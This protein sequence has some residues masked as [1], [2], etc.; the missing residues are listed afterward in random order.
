MQHVCEYT[1]DGADPS[2]QNPACGLPAV[3]CNP[4]GLSGTRE[5]WFDYDEWFCARHADPE[6][7]NE[8]HP[9]N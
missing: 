6:W 2:D 8:Q 1:A 7:L 3:V 9:T 4:H 5:R